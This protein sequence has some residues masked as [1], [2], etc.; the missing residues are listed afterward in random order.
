VNFSINFKS[1]FFLFSS[2]CDEQS[3]KQ[4]AQRWTTR[5]REVS[6]KELAPRI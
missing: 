6:A 3:R 2:A 4:E 1:V 5:R